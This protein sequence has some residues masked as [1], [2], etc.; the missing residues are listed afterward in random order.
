MYTDLNLNEQE[1]I[2]GVIDNQSSSPS[3]P[4]VGQI[5]YDNTDN[6]VKYWNGSSWLSIGI[7]AGYFQCSLATTSNINELTPTTL[8]LG[9]VDFDSIGL[10]VGSTEI[11]GF[12][13]GKYKVTLVIG[14]NDGVN[15]SNIELQIAVNSTIVKR[16][17]GS[18]YR[19]GNRGHG[20]VGDI[21]SAFVEINNVSD[22]ISFSTQRM[23]QSGI[24]TIEPSRS[25]VTIEKVN[26]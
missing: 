12:D 10:T 9:S 15:R 24:R 8:N 13:V 25:W 3:S 7:Y 19:R 14:T 5:Y 6:S 2:N 23:A 22:T 18:N 26:G 20:S 1:L 16:K 11:S 17:F 21:I 4:S